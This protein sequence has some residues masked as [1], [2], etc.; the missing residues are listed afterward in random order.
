MNEIFIVMVLLY[1]FYFSVWLFREKKKYGYTVSFY[2]IALYFFSSISGGI[3]FLF[4][5]ETIKYPE[6]VT[7]LSVSSHLLL[8]TLFLYPV[9]RFGNH[10]RIENLHVKRERL[11]QYAWCVV[12]ASML[13]MVASV[14]NIIRVFS[15]G[16]LREARTEVIYGDFTFSFVEQYG[17]IGYFLS[18]GMFISFVALILFFYYFFYL[19]TKGKLPIFLFVSSFATVV[20]N[21]AG[22][23]REGF[24]RWFFCLF[25]AFF[26]FRRTVISYIRKNRHNKKIWFSL[27]VFGS[28]L[29]YIFS[30]ITSDRFESTEE[31]VFYSLL[32]YFGE[33]YYIYS[34]HFN[35]FA[36]AVENE[37]I[38]SLFPILSPHAE[39]ISRV[40]LNERISADYFLNTFPTFAGSIMRRIGIYNSLLL[41]FISFFFMSKW[42]KRRF[43]RSYSLSRF[44][45][46][47]F[48]YEVFMMGVFYN[49]YSGRITQFSIL[50]FIILA[51]LLVDSK[52][53]RIYY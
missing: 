20:V 13:S 45:T 43:E 1:I 42:F 53:H 44:V 25:F 6:R 12:I 24:I 18:L 26:L 5:P 3:L 41:A 21:L 50:F 9:I 10:L 39:Q 34:Y 46:Y 16:N 23:G 15:F 2:L 49:M 35:R 11:D 17:V 52:R 8:L 36:H 38:L 48:I 40:N 4:Y 33:Q 7:L 22:A 14:P 28:V 37:N 29:I 51:A 19:R 47:L 32:R 31:G 30:S 27:I